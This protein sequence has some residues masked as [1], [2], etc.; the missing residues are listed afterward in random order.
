MTIFARDLTAEQ[1]SHL[2]GVIKAKLVPRVPKQYQLADV[3]G[4]A[5]SNFSSFLDGIKGA[6]IALAFRVAFLLDCP[7]EDVLGMPRMPAIADEH[8]RRYPTRILAARAAYLD[9]VP[10]TRIV[11]VLS[12]SLKYEGD[13]GVDWWMKMM[14]SKSLAMPGSKDDTQRAIK[15]IEAGQTKAIARPR[16][17]ARKRK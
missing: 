3:L 7:V 4:M 14:R 13:P 8:E 17:K 16:V 6:S 12:S 15:L 2:C 11:R 1:N 5:Q 10:L 9:G